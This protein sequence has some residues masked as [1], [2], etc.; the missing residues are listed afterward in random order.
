MSGLDRSAVGGGKVTTELPKLGG[1]ENGEGWF[2]AVNW[3]AAASEARERFVMIS[4]GAHYGAQLVGAHHMV[5]RVNPLPCTL[6]AVEAEPEN[7]AWI[8]ASHARQRHRSQRALA[9]AEGDQ[10]FQRAG[11]FSGRGSRRGLEQLFRNQHGDS[12][13]IYADLIVRDGDPKAALRSIFADNT[14]GFTQPV[15]PGLPQMTEIKFVS[16]ITLAE[17]LAPF[18]RVDFV[19][20]DIQQSE[21]VVFPPCMNALRRKVRRVHI[22]THS[23]DVHDHLHSLFAEDG[24]E[25]VFSFKPN[26]SY[27]T[28]LGNFELN[29]G[30]LTVRNPTL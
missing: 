13:Q 23:N 4:L 6:V 19:E 21:I 3:I 11:A 16:A 24:W 28:A 12:R 5:Q 10:R 22:G 29:D 30:V 26:S 7:F 25:I 15:H 27:E 8:S 2:E 18:D 14:T 20:A 17:L 1:G 9:G